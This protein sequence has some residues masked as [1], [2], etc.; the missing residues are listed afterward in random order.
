MKTELTPTIT[1]DIAFFREIALN[2][3]FITKKD[4][5]LL[6]QSVPGRTTEFVDSVAFWSHARFVD[7]LRYSL[8][9]TPC[10]EV[11]QGST[12]SHPERVQQ[13]FPRDRDL[14]EMSAESYLGCPIRSASHHVIGHI[15]IIDSKPIANEA[16]LLTIA[17]AFASLAASEFDRV[18]MI[19]RVLQSERRYRVLYDSTPAIFFTVLRDHTVTS[20]NAFGVAKLGFA[21]DEMVGRSLLDIVLPEDVEACRENIAACFAGDDRVHGWTVRKRHR[22]GSSARYKLTARVIDDASGSRSLLIVA[23]DVTEAHAR[24]EIL[25]LQASHDPLTGLLNRRE[26]ESSLEALLSAGQATPM[27]HALCYLDLDDFKVVNDR[28][29][30]AAGDELLKRLAQVLQS[31]IRKADTLARIGG[32]E[33][34]VLMRDCSLEQAG[35]IADELTRKVRACGFDCAGERFEIGVSIGVVA[36][37]GSSPSMPAVLQAAD[38]ACYAA[39][40]AGRGRVHLHRGLPG[41]ATSRLRA[42]RNT[43]STD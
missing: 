26:L 24:T 38:A 3:A 40:N 37:T 15:A 6:S 19:E 17:Q 21:R 8:D 10:Q 29:G 20:L 33:F 42:D 34:V 12:V 7:N 18:R 16:E 22:D 43:T 27:Q 35:H 30:H 25:S 41:T 13:S 5:V 36:I 39:K 2:L 28:C 4:H 23:E 14:I 11:L 1:P 31:G 32:D 9:G